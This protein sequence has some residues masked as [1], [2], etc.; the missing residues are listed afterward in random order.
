MLHGGLKIPILFSRVKNNILPPENELHFFA[1]PRIKYKK[2]LWISA[3]PL[4]GKRWW[5]YV[6]PQY[7]ENLTQ[8]IGTEESRIFY[9][10][11]PCT[12]NIF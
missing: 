6:L 8:P 4:H 7:L 11:C 5:P 9:E 2:E 1:P 10:I 12:G 3:N